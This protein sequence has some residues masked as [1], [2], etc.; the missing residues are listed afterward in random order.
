VL[1]VG[2]SVSLSPAAGIEAYPQRLRMAVGPEWQVATIVHSGKTVEEMEPEI[3]EALG[4]GPSAIVLQV[5]INECAPRPLGPS[6][7][8]RLGAL[9]PVWLRTAIIGAIHRWRPHIIRLRPLAQFTPLDRFAASVGRIVEAARPFGVR[10]LILPITAVTPAAEARTPFTNREVAR[11]NDA[12]RAVAGQTG[13]WV[14]TATLLP[15]LTPIDY[16][17][18]PETVHW[19]AAAHARVAEFIVAWLRAGR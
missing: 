4:K 15:T 19:S 16:C 11:Y 1:I 14:D 9:R 2:N 18:E 7:R 5:G 8:R 12:L 3:L 13:T 10:M 17:H 6:G